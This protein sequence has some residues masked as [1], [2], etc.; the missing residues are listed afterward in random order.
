MIITGI[1]L[2]LMGFTVWKFAKAYEKN[3]VPLKTK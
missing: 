3:A 1:A 2:F